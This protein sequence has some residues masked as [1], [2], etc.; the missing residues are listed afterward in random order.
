MECMNYFS[1]HDKIDPNIKGMLIKTM[2]PLIPHISEELWELNGN[3]ASVFDESYP[4]YD[5]SLVIDDTV[6][7]AIQVNGKL[8]GSIEVEKTIDK[9]D[10]LAFAKKQENVNIHLKDKNIIKEIIVPERL[11]N[12]VVK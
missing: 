4:K 3:S 2:A 7:I 8:R 9:E 12:F 10:L 6:S 1:N 5:K 11:I